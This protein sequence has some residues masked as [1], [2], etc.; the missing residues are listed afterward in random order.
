MNKLWE[1]LVRWRTWLVNVVFA[2]LLTPELLMALLGFDWGSIIP[3][4]YMPYVTLAVIVLNV[5]MRPRPAS[6]A[7]DP[8]VQVKM[9]ISETSDP[10]T[11]K[12]IENGETKA[13]IRA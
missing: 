5:W 13:V 1:T 11:I 7:S 4:K 10:S 9:A 3:A 8:E 6:V 12:V 2:I